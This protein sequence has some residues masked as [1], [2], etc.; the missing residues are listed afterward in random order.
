MGRAMERK[1][2]PRLDALKKNP[3]HNAEPAFS[4]QFNMKMRPQHNRARAA[5]RIAETYFGV[6]YFCRQRRMTK[7]ETPCRG[8]GY[9]RM[10]DA[11]NAG[12]RSAKRLHRT[13]H[14]F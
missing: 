7:A 13:K 4:A 10:G 5:R 14:R 9:R 3:E 6:G 11:V 1:N 8:E 12:R 2:R